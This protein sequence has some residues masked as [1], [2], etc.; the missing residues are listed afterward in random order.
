MPAEDLTILRTYLAHQPWEFGP[1]DFY[2]SH[3]LALYVNAH[4]PAR[5]KRVKHTDFLPD[6]LKTV[7]LEEEPELGDWEKIKESLMVWAKLAKGKQDGK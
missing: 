5:A 6:F 3:F 7:S 1:I 4:M 2:L